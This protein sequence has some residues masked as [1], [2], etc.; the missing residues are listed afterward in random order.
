MSQTALT[1]ELRCEETAIWRLALCL[2]P[3]PNRFAEDVA[4]IASKLVVDAAALARIIRHVQAIEVMSSRGVAERGTL[5]AAKRRRAGDKEND[6][7]S[8]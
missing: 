7:P 4:M 5:M 3:R 2:K 6:E 8:H 1:A